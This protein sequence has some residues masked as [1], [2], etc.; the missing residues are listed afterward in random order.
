M[1]LISYCRSKEEANE[2][3]NV[4][5]EKKFFSLRAA[6]F[7]GRGL[8]RTDDEPAYGILPLKPAE[9]KDIVEDDQSQRHY[10][11]DHYAQK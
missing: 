9:F 3:F 11:D 2:F 10:I 1:A 4:L 8:V 7:G 5:G 6:A